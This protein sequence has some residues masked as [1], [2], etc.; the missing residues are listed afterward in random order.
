[1]KSRFVRQYLFAVVLLVAS[2]L[3][4]SAAPKKESAKKE[5]AKDD[6]PKM[7]RIVAQMIT[8]A[9]KGDVV[10]K[11]KTLYRSGKTFARVEEEP[12]PDTNVHRLIITN[13]P[14]S[15]VINLLDRTGG[16][17]IDQGT[18]LDTKLPIFWGLDGKPDKDF[19]ALEFGGEMAFFGKDRARD[20]GSKKL[21]GKNYK[22]RSIKTGEHEVI[23]FLDPKGDRPYQIDLIK[24]GRLTSS[25]RY[26]A[27]ETNL[28]FNQTLFR[29]PEGVNITDEKKF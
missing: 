26:I 9:P 11:P 4:A 2:S 14:D 22:T 7:T 3:V 1:M 16:H 12:D 28:K 18:D 8:H 20:S 19:E 5:G 17:F 24:Y 29:P 13:P 6:T 15:W 21:E 23:L 10:A 25:V 27:Y